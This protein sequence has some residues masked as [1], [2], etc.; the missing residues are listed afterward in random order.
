[1]IIIF[2]G[3]DCVGKSSI[4][5]EIVKLLGAEKCI[6]KHFAAPPKSLNAKMQHDWNKAD[7]EHELVLMQQFGSH[8]HFI[9]D[10]YAL[11]ESV[12]APRYRNYY[13][14]YMPNLL[15]RVSK[16]GAILVLVTCSY[17]VAESRFD[18]KGMPKQDIRKVIDIF[19]FMFDIAPFDRKVKID[20]SVKKPDVLASELIDIIKRK[21]WTSANT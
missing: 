12:Y 2:E 15:A 14:N 4:V 7:Y 13:P 9:Y 3:S 19:N 8:T 20:T 18:G 17:D 6:V 10:R 16:L 5:A 11:G 21:K 1:M